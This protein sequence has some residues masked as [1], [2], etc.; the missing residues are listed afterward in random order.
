MNPSDM[1]YDSLKG[2]STYTEQPNTQ[3]SRHPSV[4][5]AE[6]KPAM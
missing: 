2:T 6:F 4:L 5:Q 3:K 1:W